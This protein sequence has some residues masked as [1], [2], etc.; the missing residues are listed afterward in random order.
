M[1]LVFMGV[2]Q[3]KYVSFRNNNE[4]PNTKYTPRPVN[5]DLRSQRG[6]G[7]IRNQ[8]KCSSGWAFA[9]ISVL[10]YNYWRKTNK[11]ID[12]S[13]QYYIDCIYPNT[14]CDNPGNLLEAMH[15]AANAGIPREIDYP[16]VY[17]QESC[18]KTMP[19][20]VKYNSYVYDATILTDQ[21]F[22]DNIFN[23]GV[24]A[25]GVDTTGWD[26]YT[27]GIFVSPNSNGNLTVNH[28]VTLVGYG[29]ENDIPYWLARNSW[30]NEWF[31]KDEAI[32]GYIR[33][34]ARRHANGNV[35]GG[36]VFQNNVHM[37][38]TDIYFV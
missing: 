25:V 32:P 30:G 35:Y 24:V 7:C 15:S 11:T 34:D 3:A 17:K 10:E 19:P 14:S 37:R 28:F 2:V 22:I 21:R 20:A 12:L 13:E 36:V 29:K 6:I 8:G 38:P 26:S 18:R 33:L 5:Y 4:T 9:I 27:G 16:N 31:G 23:H 1:P